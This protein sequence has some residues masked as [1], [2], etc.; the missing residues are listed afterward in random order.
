[1]TV[2]VLVAGVG[3]VFLGD[4]G[5][6]VEVARRLAAEQV[7][8][9]VCVADYGI[10]AVHLAYDLLDGYD[11]LVLVDALGRGDE[12]GTLYAI[13]PD[14]GGALSGSPVV[15]AHGMTPDTVLG[16]FGTLGGGLDRTVVVGCEPADCSEGMELSATVAG[17]VGPALAL[18]REVLA[19]IGAGAGAGEPNPKEG[20]RCSA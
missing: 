9:G 10:R 3:N 4:D 2:R 13:E 18:V 16:L 5:F 8:D 6:G 15:D 17:A 20:R 19:E 12:P 14:P 7:P 1:M 11:A